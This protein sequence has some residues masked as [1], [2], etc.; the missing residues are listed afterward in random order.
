M[1]PVEE[2]ADKLGTINY[3]VTCMIAARVPRVYFSGG[4]VVGVANP[5]LQ[6]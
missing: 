5:I 4:K 2:L 6:R 1:L 3:E